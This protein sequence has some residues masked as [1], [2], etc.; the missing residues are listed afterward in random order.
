M[1]SDIVARLRESDGGYF[2]RQMFAEAADEIERLRF[3]RDGFREGNR[4]TLAALAEA[5][6]IAKRYKAERDSARRS[7]CEMT[8]ELGTV[9]RRV[10]GNTVEVTTPEYV[11][12]LMDWDC[13]KEKR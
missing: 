1:E 5:N 8:L 4:Q 10:N 9:F 11:A 13:F 12:D 6:E 2:M 3:E 7:V